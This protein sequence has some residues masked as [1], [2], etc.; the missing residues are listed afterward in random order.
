MMSEVGLGLVMSMPADLTV[1]SAS[2]SSFQDN[3]LGNPTINT[4]IS[5]QT[6]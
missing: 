2:Q 6:N 1:C 5:R 3:Q 4:D